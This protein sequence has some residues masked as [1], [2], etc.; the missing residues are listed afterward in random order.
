MVIRV[1]KT[2]GRG[3]AALGGLQV[4]GRHGHALLGLTLYFCLLAISSFAFHPLAPF[5]SWLSHL[6]HNVPE[7]HA[8]L[9]SPLLFLLF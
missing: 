3:G 6:R 5:L 2:L 1:R 4:L 9:L 8:A 7:G